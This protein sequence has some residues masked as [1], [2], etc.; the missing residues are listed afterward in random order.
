MSS[1]KSQFIDLDDSPLNVTCL[2]CESEFNIPKNQ[3][4]FLVHLLEKHHLVIGD[5]DKIA[6]FKR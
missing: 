2:L 4:E 1:L 3:N 6:S 5:I